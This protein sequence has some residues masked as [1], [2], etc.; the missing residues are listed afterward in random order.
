M[1]LQDVREGCR[2][3]VLN[4]RI[5]HTREMNVIDDFFVKE[6][7]NSAFNAKLGAK[8]LFACKKIRIKKKYLQPWKSLF[9][10]TTVDKF[11]KQ[12]VRQQ[13]IQAAGACVEASA[14]KVLTKQRKR[15]R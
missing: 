2:S 3:H 14:P 9:S 4:D 12:K 1:Y 15:L 6:K 13:E 11:Q 5:I 7:Y 10:V 8:S